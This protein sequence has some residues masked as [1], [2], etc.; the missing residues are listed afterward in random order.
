MTDTD[1]NY[2][3][4]AVPRGTYLVRV[5]STA[6][7][8]TTPVEAGKIATFNLDVAARAASRVDKEQDGSP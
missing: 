7:A 2:H 1:G 6:S 8:E 5:L 3:V 4:S